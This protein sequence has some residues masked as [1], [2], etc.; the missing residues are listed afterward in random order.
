VP[1]VGFYAQVPH[2]VGGPY[3]AASVSLLRHLGRH[4]GVE[5]PVQDL[6][7]EAETQR[8]RLDAA[9]AADDDVRELLDRMEQSDAEELPSGD[10]L[11]AEIERFLRGQADST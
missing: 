3:S 10:E 6:E 9:V 2:Y 1:A 5:I 4:L 8:Q 11:A 7:Q